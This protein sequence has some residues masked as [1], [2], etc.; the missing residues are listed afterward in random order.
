MTEKQFN[1][2]TAYQLTMSM[3][4]KMLE[5]RLISKEEY[6][7]IDTIMLRKYEPLLGSIYR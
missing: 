7:E 4:R 3:V 6:A 5:Q 2:E 1:S